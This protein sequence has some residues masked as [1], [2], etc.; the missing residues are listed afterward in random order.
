VSR[1]AAETGSSMLKDPLDLWLNEPLEPA[2]KIVELAI[3]QAQARLRS[4]QKVEKEKKGSQRRRAAGQAHRLQLQRCFAHRTVF[5]RGDSPVASASR[6]A[7]RNSKP[8]CRCAA[9][10]AEH[11]RGGEGI[12][13]SRTTEDSRHRRCRLVLTRTHRPTPSISPACATTAILIMA[14]ADVDGSHIS[15]CCSP[16]IPPLLPV[17]EAA[18]STSRNRRCSASTCRAWQEAGEQDLRA[19]RR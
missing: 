14:D 2:K 19:E 13:C 8:C 18:R 4:A 17:V 11:L 9:K 7:T 6:D 3:Q 15:R 1:D 16:V 5:G 10:R 12:A